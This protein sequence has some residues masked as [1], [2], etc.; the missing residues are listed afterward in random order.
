MCPKRYQ[1]ATTA[2]RVSGTKIMLLANYKI[3][4]GEAMW[5]EIVRKYHFPVIK[6]L[7]MELQYLYQQFAIS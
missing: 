6:N 5:S 2:R 3:L 4:Q 1:T 7:Q